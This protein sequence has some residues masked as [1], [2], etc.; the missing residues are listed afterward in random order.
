MNQAKTRLAALALLD[1]ALA[2]VADEDIDRLAAALNPELR[3]AY[4]ELIGEQWP[5]PADTPEGE[6]APVELVPVAVT[7]REAVG[8]GRI[9]GTLERVAAVLSDT[10]LEDCVT[11]L[12]DAADNPDEEQLLAVTDGLIERHGLS[13]VQLMLAS[14]VAGEAAAAPLC[15]RLLK[16]HEVLALPAPAVSGPPLR[17]QAS[18]DDPARAALRDKRKQD[19]ARK[20][21]EQRARREQA[22]R[23]GHRG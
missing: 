7:T 4:A 6:A 3:A 9:S 15:I 14:A 20:Q 5:R 10:C 19:K 21:A 17:Q 11:V 12:G 8:R 23:A 13:T 2:N 1:R 22:S 16:H 18:G